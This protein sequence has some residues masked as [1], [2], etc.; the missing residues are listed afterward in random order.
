MFLKKI[1]IIIDISLLISIIYV[2]KISFLRNLNTSTKKYIYTFINI[3]T[4][5]SNIIFEYIILKMLIFKCMF[6][7]AFWIYHIWIQ[8]NVCFKSSIALV[9]CSNGNCWSTT[10]IYNYDFY[11]KKKILL[12]TYNTNHKLSVISSMFISYEIMQFII[13]VYARIRFFFL[14]Y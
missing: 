2:L 12:R 5:R 6:R 8:T 11:K 9:D 4:S 10:F 14:F 13:K 1:T 3:W 7:I